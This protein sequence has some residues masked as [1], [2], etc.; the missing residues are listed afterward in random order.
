M[1]AMSSSFPV[2]APITVDD[3]SSDYES[4]TENAYSDSEGSGSSSV[5]YGSEFEEFASGEEFESA[6]EKPFV[7]EERE[8][9]RLFGKY[10]VSRPFVADP[11]EGSLGNSVVDEEEEEGFGRVI[12]PGGLGLGLGLGSGLM[13]I[14]QLSIDEDDVHELVFDE[15]MV[16]G[17]EDGR[18]GGVEVV[19]RVDSM[20]RVRVSDIEEDKDDELLLQKVGNGVELGVNGDVKRVFDGSVSDE[21]AKDKDLVEKNESVLR[22]NVELSDVKH[23]FDDSVSVELV[24]KKEANAELNGDVKDVFDE[25]VSGELVKNDDLVEKNE[26]GLRENVELSEDV[27]HVFDDSVPVELVKE[28]DLVEEKKEA[29]LKETAEL[30]GDGKDVFDDAVSDEL[31]KDDDLVEKKEDELKKS[32]SFDDDF[33]E[34]R[35]SYGDFG[36]ENSDTNVGDEPNAKKI[37]FLNHV[38]ERKEQ[39]GEAVDV[40]VDGHENELNQVHKILAEL[41]ELE[42][43]DGS[44]NAVEAVISPEEADEATS[45]EIDEKGVSVDDSEKLEDKT[46]RETDGIHESLFFDA[47]MEGSSSLS[48]SIVA[49]DNHIEGRVFDDFDSDSDEETE[50]GKERKGKD[51]FDPASFAA[52]LRAAAGAELDGGKITLTSADGRVFSVE[53]PGSS[54]DT[55][56][57][58]STSQSDTVK[59]VADKSITEEDKKVVEK[60]HHIRVK[61]LR[62]VQRLGLSPEDSVVAQVLYQLVL[63]AGGHVSDEFSLEAAKRTA[64]QLEGM[65]EDDDLDFSLNILVIGKTGVGK[66]ATINSIF[67]EKKVLISAFEPATNTVKEIVG[68][69]NGVK[70]RVL[71][72]PGFRSSLKEEATNRKILASIKKLT[73]KFPPDVVLYVDRLDTYTRDFNDLPL[74]ASIT[75][76]LTTSIWRNAIVVL[77]HAAAVPPDG[78]YGYPLSFETFIGRRSHVVQ[79][80]ISQAVGDIR[81]MGSSMMHPLALVENHPSCRKN[82]DG[83]SILSN[84]QSWRPQ[85]LLL[86]YSL[87]ILS[88]ANSIKK[89]RN[90]FN[91]KKL[92]GQLRSLPAPQLL[93][94]LLQPRPHPKL[95]PEQGGDDVDSDVELLDLSDSDEEDEDE[96]DQLPPFKPLKKTEVNRLSKEQ[97]KAY[98]EEYDYRVNLLQK[99][100]LKDE[101]KRSKELKQIKDSSEYVN[102]E[103]EEG[104][105]A[106][107]PVAMPELSLP[108]SFDSDNPSYRYRALEPTSQLLIRPVLDSQGWDHD[109]GYDGV[110]LESNLAIANKFP[111]A[112]S[113][114]ITKDKKD[115]SIHIDSSIC[116]KHPGSGSTM[117]GLEIQ[118]LGR[119]LVYILKTDSQF[120]NFKL[121]K[122]SAGLSLAMSGENVATGL[123]IEDQI[124]FGKQLAMAGSAGAMRSKGETAFGANFE[125]RMKNKDYPVNQNQS[126]LGFSLLKWRSDLNYMANLQSQ[127]SIGRNSKMAV[128][129]GMNN[130]QSGQISIKNSS[131]ELQI[132]AI[133]IFPI[134]AS[135]VRNL[136]PGTA[137][138]S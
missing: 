73:K 99:K 127:F 135:V 36:L 45:F 106:N 30:N 87:K 47:E 103:E 52:L 104:G 76:S 9:S 102:P 37:D 4:Q 24:E 136:C 117:A 53:N 94:S 83:E 69:V 16:S 51:I 57:K 10:G 133:C 110:N 70:I 68:A 50:T 72:S 81:L 74:L 113:V 77:T 109:I 28:D 137:A 6:S 84:G 22:E 88:E 11:D 34:A 62:L 29:I 130:K 35:L 100:Q 126:T 91:Q 78:P 48:P 66:S 59:D 128:R 115:F 3:E 61:F 101:I 31:V 124:T 1:A 42:V 111:G 64:L 20:P 25:A 2:R 40:F 89:P 65:G 46:A 86:C 138:R 97:R 120:K 43:D 67:G 129:V 44:N 122:T 49:D 112:F 108:M 79:Q 132:A 14:A 119:Q 7:D 71:D 15:G 55:V 38:S 92:F 107:V 134:L 131:S 17:E 32:S 5:V 93:S 121:N 98:F 54:F 60:I 21:L 19:A 8:D 80:A 105:P 82:A 114:Q 12:E 23:V 125:I 63:A 90:P 33:V 85:L 123:K 116:A 118:N 75:S 41:Q 27:K 58:T 56:G 18:F 39:I 26:V 95:S 13:P 96:Y